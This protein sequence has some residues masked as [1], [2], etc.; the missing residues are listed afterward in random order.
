M[1]AFSRMFNYSQSGSTARPPVAFL[2]SLVLQAAALALLCHIP[3]APGSGTFPHASPVLPSSA[4]MPIYFENAPV[5]A[6]SI[7]QTTPVA[8]QHALETPVVEAMPQAKPPE[9][10][11]EAAAQPVTMPD[12]STHDS[13]THDSSADDSSGKGEQAAVAPFSEWQGNAT[14]GGSAFMHHQVKTALPVFTPDPPVLHGDL[15]EPARGKDIVMNVVINEQGSIVQVAVLQGVGYG[16]ENSIVDTLR[17]WIFVPAKIN[18]VAIASQRQLR[19]HL[20][21]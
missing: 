4:V 2:A 7:S 1:I 11:Q 14:P 15:P 20:P 9:T 13:S 6:P 16:V 19:F 8:S 10:K 5:P 12:S 17:R 18:G 3:F 21:S